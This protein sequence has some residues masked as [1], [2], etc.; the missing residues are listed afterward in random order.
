MLVPP[1]TAQGV[2]VNEYAPLV[3][4]F[5]VALLAP[6]IAGLMPTRARLPQVVLLLLGGVVIGPQLLDVAGPDD[7][8]LLSDLGMGFLF[9]LAGYELEP[10]VLR[11]REGRRAGSAW[12]TSLVLGAL[13]AFL[14]LEHD[15]VHALAAGAIALTTT[16]LG[17]VSL[18]RSAACG[19]SR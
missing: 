13:V 18:M 14:L 12:L 5:V 6:L 7:V 17:I 3:P 2:A 19:H 11:E 16:A 15:T 9:L 8:S 10:S 1:S 4:V